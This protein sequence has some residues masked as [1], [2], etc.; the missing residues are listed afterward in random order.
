MSD[1]IRPS[2]IGGI[3]AEMMSNDEGRKE[4]PPCPSC[5]KHGHPGWK[6]REMDFAQAACHLLPQ[7]RGEQ[8]AEASKK[9]VNDVL[10]QIGVYSTVF[11]YN[12][13]PPGDCHDAVTALKGAL[14]GDSGSNSGTVQKTAKL[15]L[16]ASSTTARPGTSM[17]HQGF[18]G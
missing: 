17:E 12:Q 16:P 18:L 3:F 13:H 6:R 2:N 10:M 1:C 15:G 14:L 8:T 4:F 5:E 9:A 11:K 7:A